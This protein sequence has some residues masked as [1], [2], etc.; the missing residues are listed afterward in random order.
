MGDRL[1][2]SPPIESSGHGAWG[3]AAGSK[4]KYW[5]V[6]ILE[7]WGEQLGEYVSG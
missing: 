7:G 1:M 6:G 3:N 4:G 2:T 5:N